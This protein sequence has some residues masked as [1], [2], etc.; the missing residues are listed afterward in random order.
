MA[1][2]TESPASSSEAASVG[3]FRTFSLIEGVPLEVKV[4]VSSLTA[5]TVIEIVWTAVLAG[6]APSEA[7]T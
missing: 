2:V 1:K 6:S 7:V 4:G 5:L 3:T